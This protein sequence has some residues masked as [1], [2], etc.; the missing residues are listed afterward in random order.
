MS[1]SGRT[2][3]LEIPDW[4]D[5]AFAHRTNLAERIQLST[6]RSRAPRKEQARQAIQ[7]HFRQTPWDYAIQWYD[8]ISAPFGVEVRHP[9]LDRSLIEFL[10]SIPPEHLFRIGLSKPLLRKAMAR[11]LPEMVQ[12]RQ[13]KTN[14]GAFLDFTLR[15]AQRLQVERL[16]EEP[17]VVALGYVNG[18]RLR[19]A[20]RHYLNNKDVDHYRTLWYTISLEIWLRAHCGTLELFDRIPNTAQRS[21]A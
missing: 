8:C 13:D 18:T 6:K 9:F 4:I 14:L 21:V 17:L 7:E 1:L 12:R 2:R 19:S 15:E 10:S 5:P 16:L 3:F 20:Y 11:L